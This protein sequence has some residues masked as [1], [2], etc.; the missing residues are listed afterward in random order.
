MPAPSVMGPPHNNSNS[1]VCLLPPSRAPAP[2][3]SFALHS[4][5]EEVRAKRD[6][7]AKLKERYLQAKEEIKEM[8]EGHVRES[9][10]LWEAVRDLSACEV[11]SQLPL[12]SL[13]VRQLVPSVFLVLSQVF[14]RPPNDLTNRCLCGCTGGG[15]CVP[16]VPFN[17]TPTPAEGPHPQ[18]LRARGAG[19]P[20]LILEQLIVVLVWCMTL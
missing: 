18:E 17:R 2:P 13:F 5:E 11:N 14:L 8:T 6:K 15:R 10:D 7:Q 9:E 3:S 19:E 12:A 1:C 4:L 20:K 16:I